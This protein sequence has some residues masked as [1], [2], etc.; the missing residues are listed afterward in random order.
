MSTSAESSE[1]PPQSSLSGGGRES[2]PELL[3]VPPD[4][5]SSIRIVV[6]D[7]ERTL[8]ESCASFLEAE[9]YQV[10]VCGKGDEARE[11]LTARTFD[12]ALLDLYM[13]QVPGLELLQTCLKTNPNTCPM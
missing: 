1:V 13:G 8:R 6:V 7:D 5:R 9:G 10:T 12:I 2:S 4:V 11:I 3:P